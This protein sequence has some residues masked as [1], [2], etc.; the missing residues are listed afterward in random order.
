MINAI[1]RCRVCGNSNLLPVL[2]LGNQ[3]LTGVFPKSLDD[4]ITYGPLEVVKCHGEN[5]CGL[6]QLRH[7]YDLTEL[8]G[9]NYG[10]RSGLN[11]SMVAHLREKVAKV[12]TFVDELTRNDLVLDIGS[13]DGTLLGFYPEIV[14]RIGVDPTA[15]K[16]G[17]FYQPGIKVIVDFFSAAEFKQRFDSRKPKIITSVAMFYD[18]DDPIT[19]VEEVASI[20]ADDGIWHFEQSYLPAMLNMNAYD[21]VCHEHIGYYRL[22]Q[23]KWITDRC[24]LKIIDVEFNNTNG[25]SFAV[26]VAKNSSRIRE[27]SATVEH[28][29]N[30]ETYLDVLAPY[31][32]FRNRVFEHRDKLLFTL[33]TLR[34]EGAKVLGYGA[35]TKGNVILQFC[36]LTTSQIECIGDVNP[37]KFGHVTPGTGIPIVSEAEARARKPDYFLIMPWHFREGLIQ[38][39]TIFRAQGGRMIFPLPEIE[40]VP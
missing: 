34:Q 36:S 26:T 4:E 29:L 24:R 10:Y 12:Q 40:I 39:E 2:A 5:V 9:P 25:G 28:I 7:C 21:S 20:L 13:N 1:K 22:K 8:Y 27:N 11:Q 38:R 30:E 31:E 3:Y 19:F 23:I 37:D 6:V 33:G 16:F 14:T 17:E 35:S 15:N 18:L 32:R